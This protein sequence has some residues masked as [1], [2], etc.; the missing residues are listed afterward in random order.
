MTTPTMKEITIS[1]SATLSGVSPRKR[2]NADMP[3]YSRRRYGFVRADTVSQSS[4]VFK[5]AW[6]GRLSTSDAAW[7]RRDR[8]MAFRGERGGGIGVARGGERVAEAQILGKE[9]AV[10]RVA[11]PGGVDWPRRCPATWR[12]WSCVATRHALAAERQSDDFRAE[13]PR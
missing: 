8:T 1:L 11:R 6:Q 12:R 13:P 7:H 5:H 4:I 3:V 9:I 2:L 10:E